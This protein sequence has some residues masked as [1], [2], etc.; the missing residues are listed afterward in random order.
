MD[1]AS[2]IRGK[3]NQ[4]SMGLFPHNVEG[5]MKDQDNIILPS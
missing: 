2:Q 1:M 4:G 3:A 5:G